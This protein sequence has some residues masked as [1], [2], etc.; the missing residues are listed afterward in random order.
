MRISVE[1][2]V[3]FTLVRGEIVRQN[4]NQ[5]HAGY[6][7][8]LVPMFVTAPLISQRLDVAVHG[9]LLLLLSITD[10]SLKKKNIIC[11]QV[12]KDTFFNRLILFSKPHWKLVTR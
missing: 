9:A 6:H 1:I 12:S 4:D 11:W 5:S 3:E 10:V 2:R 8:P 7:T